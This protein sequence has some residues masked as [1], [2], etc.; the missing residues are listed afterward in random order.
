[1]T[2]SYERLIETGFGVLVLGDLTTQ[3]VPGG[4][5]RSRTEAAQADSVP[6]I[7][8]SPRR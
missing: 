2:Q 8:R 1:M 7:A 6:A 5:L 3:R 4:S